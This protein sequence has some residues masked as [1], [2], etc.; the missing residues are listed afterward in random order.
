[1]GTRR[2]RARTCTVAS[3]APGSTIPLAVSPFAFRLPVEVQISIF[4]LA[5]HS[6][7]SAAYLTTVRLSQVCR[8]WRRI[9]QSTPCLWTKLILS[10][11]KLGSHG[12]T[13]ADSQ[14]VL[15]ERP[16][17]NHGALS[18]YLQRSGQL[19]L[20]LFISQGYV[21]YLRNLILSPGHELEAVLPLL[22]QF[23]NRSQVVVFPDYALFYGPDET[24]TALLNA[25]NNSEALL[26]LRILGGRPYGR[27]L[28]PQLINRLKSLEIPRL[29]WFQQVEPY[30][31]FLPGSN[32]QL[33]HLEVLYEEPWTRFIHVTEK[34]TNLTTLRLV[35]TPAD[36]RDMP[37]MQTLPNLR[38]LRLSLGTAIRCP[39]RSQWTIMEFL[40]LPVLNDLRLDVQR[41]PPAWASGVLLAFFQRSP[42]IDSFTFATT[43]KLTTTTI[44]VLDS[45][46][47]SQLRRLQ[48]S[49][50]GVID[51]L[52]DLLSRTRLCI[53]TSVRHGSTTYH[54]ETDDGLDIH[55]HS[56]VFHRLEYLSGT[57]YR[58]VPVE[59]MSCFVAAR[60]S[61]AAC[62][63]RHS[64]H[65]ISDT[66]S[67][68]RERNRAR[69]S[70]VADFT[71]KRQ[72]QADQLEESTCIEDP[73][74]ARGILNGFRLDITNVSEYEV[75]VHLCLDNFCSLSQI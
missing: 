35:L 30:P 73:I 42:L 27:S 58:S 5:D 23:I 28:Q 15:D 51:P 43:G 46:S 29:H 3:N 7:M 41:A 11:P 52:L 33:R 18:V 32:N 22:T 71:V 14:H 70:F 31:D 37:H 45:A 54:S 26:S 48:V 55:T 57:Y 10:T 8:E 60:T 56:C 39:N 49:V 13:V 44:D 63:E 40:D 68:P 34:F 21:V 47:A 59:K 2:S 16:E 66:V 62:E 72:Q 69:R 19:R 24:P 25:L 53:A 12:R 75:S 1:M 61:G 6:C 17:R 64:L 67:A 9:T 4:Q 50:N 20:C 65:D 38:E 74:I 36:E